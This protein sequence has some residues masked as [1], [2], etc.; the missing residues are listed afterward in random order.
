MGW[1]MQCSLLMFHTRTI[2]RNSDNITILNES[3]GCLQLSGLVYRS[4]LKIRPWAM[5]SESAQRGDGRI[6]EDPSP[7]NRTTLELKVGPPYFHDA[8]LGVLLV[9][10]TLVEDECYVVTNYK[11]LQVYCT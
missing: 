4:L 10:K 8:P 3:C 1:C 9:M 6:F 2:V 7:E 11:G 5:N